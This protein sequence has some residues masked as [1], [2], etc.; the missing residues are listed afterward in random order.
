MVT[1]T[2]YVVARRFKAAQ[3]LNEPFRIR[4]YLGSAMPHV[5]FREL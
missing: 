4:T 3:S 5:G 1:G 2:C